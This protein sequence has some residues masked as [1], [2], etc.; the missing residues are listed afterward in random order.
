MNAV[1]LIPLRGG[2]KGIPGKNIKLLSGK[3]LFYWV[4]KAALDAGLRVYIST[5]SALIKKSVH[6][7]FPN[8][9][10]VDRPASLA[11]D[12]VSTEDV[13]KHF[14]SVVS[15]DHL[16]LLQATSPM[17]LGPHLKD[18]LG[19]YSRHGFKPLVSVTRQ[20][21]FT[22]SDNGTP[23]NYDPCSRP[24]R[25]DWTGQLVENGAFY[26]FSKT[27][28]LSHHCRCAPPVTLFELPCAHSLELDTPDDWKLMESLFTP[29]S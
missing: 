6:D 2:S 29:G 23:L 27:N 14:F 17:T 8:V 10:V 28:F 4:T 9:F 20:H 24:R 7:Y 11:T 13:V 1:A 12:E 16:V 19:K 3:P 18:A 26:I 15:V 22:W 25:Q 21:M 5:D